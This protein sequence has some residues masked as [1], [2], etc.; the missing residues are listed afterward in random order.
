MPQSVRFYS[1]IMKKN[2]QAQAG[3]KKSLLALA[4][5]AV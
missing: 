3:S 1:S 5:S 4:L 2:G